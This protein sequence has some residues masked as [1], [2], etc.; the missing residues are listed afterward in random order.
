MTYSAWNNYSAIKL[1]VS[2]LSCDRIT[3]NHC[4]F[5]QNKLPTRKQQMV[6]LHSAGLFVA[7]VIINAECEAVVCIILPWPACV[8]CML[9]WWQNHTVALIKSK[10]IWYNSPL[11]DSQSESVLK[12]LAAF[13]YS[14]NAHVSLPG[15]FQPLMR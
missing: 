9:Q 4:S 5:E 14:T 2:T 11:K 13:S 15:S 10:Q 8:C 3:T 6:S 12:H 1:A 7:C